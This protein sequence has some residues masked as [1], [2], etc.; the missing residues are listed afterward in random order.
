M[1]IPSPV[2]EHLVCVN[3]L[4][5]DH[6]PAEFSDCTDLQR[7]WQVLAR[8]RS[9]EFLPSFRVCP[10]GGG[11]LLGHLPGCCL[12][13]VIPELLLQGPVALQ[14]SGDG[15]AGPGVGASAFA[16]LRRDTMARPPFSP[17]VQGEDGR[18]RRA[19]EGSTANYR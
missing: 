16:G 19:A 9:Q 13:R 5:D 2:K 17:S 7:V 6:A 18:S 12:L 1:P 3:S 4:E 15:H 8:I 14:F 10:F 11:F